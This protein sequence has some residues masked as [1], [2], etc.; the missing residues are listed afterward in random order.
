MNHLRA[1]NPVSTTNS[2]KSIITI[3]S[4]KRSIWY[5]QLHPT[6]TKIPNKFLKEKTLP[7]RLYSKI[8]NAA[9]FHSPLPSLARLLL[10]LR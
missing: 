1:A 10:L 3:T 9:F 5:K 8:P 7:H 2:K 4:H 6:Q